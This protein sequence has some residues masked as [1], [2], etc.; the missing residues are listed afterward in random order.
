MTNSKLTKKEKTSKLDVARYVLLGICLIP[1][2]IVLVAFLCYFIFYLIPEKGISKVL[3]EQDIDVWCLLAV[4][5]FLAITIAGL[6][7]T[8]R[9]MKAVL[10]T[11]FLMKVA[12]FLTL[13]GMLIREDDV[14]RSVPNTFFGIAIGIVVVL[15]YIFNSVKETNPKKNKPPR[16]EAAPRRIEFNGFD[17]EGARARAREEYLYLHNLIHLSFLLL[18]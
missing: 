17:V 15:F 7:R 6:I 11:G 13:M 10:L 5:M 3:H 2:G 9:K 18:L 1:E 8:R 16:F 14:S 4:A 12:V